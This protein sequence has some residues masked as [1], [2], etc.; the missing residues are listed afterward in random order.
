M[1][2]SYQVDPELLPQAI[3]DLIEARS[4]LRDLRQKAQEL[5]RNRPGR[6][7]D[8]VSLNSGTE[9]S[10]VAGDASSGSLIH[11]VNMYEEAIDATLENFRQMLASYLELEDVNQIPDFEGEPTPYSS[12]PSYAEQERA[13]QG[14]HH[15][16]GN[17]A[18]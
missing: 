13:R 7:A 12:S 16:N 6:G 15:G 17:I 18:V 3:A 2:D 10:R 4:Q 9:L 1:G 8:Q 5:A 11:T 14:Y